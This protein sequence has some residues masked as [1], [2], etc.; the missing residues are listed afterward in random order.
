MSAGAH[1][2]IV[3]AAQQLV[4]RPCCPAAMLFCVAVYI[5]CVVWS[6]RCVTLSLSPCAGAKFPVKWTAPEAIEFS[7]FTIKSDV[8]AFGILLV[9]LTTGGATPYP[10][11]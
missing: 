5:G 9:E 1:A 3:D 2:C 8:W 6:G 4:L 11:L 7:Q 10:G